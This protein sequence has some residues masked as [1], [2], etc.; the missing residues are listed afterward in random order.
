MIVPA[1]WRS[2]V[3]QADWS[4]ATIATPRTTIDQRGIG[5]ID[6]VQ[7]STNT[8]WKATAPSTSIIGSPIR[9]DSRKLSGPR[10]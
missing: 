1:Q 8:I 5:R 9:S 7:R 3:S 10:R 2:W 4:N 6:A